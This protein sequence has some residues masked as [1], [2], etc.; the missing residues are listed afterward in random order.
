M[1]ETKIAVIGGTGLYEMEGVTPVDTFDIDTPFGTPSDSITVVD[2]DGKNVAFLPR[3]GRGHRYLPTEIPVKAN[4]WALKKLGVE[5][6]VAFSAVG[7]LRDQIRPR[8]IVVPDQII[9]RT[10]SRENSFFGEGIAG[11]VPFA[12][13]FCPAL[14]RV[15]AEIVASLPYPSH[16]EGTYVCMEGPLFSTRAESNL[17][18]SWGGS[19][20]GMT[21]IPEAKLAREAEICYS[22]IT[23]VTDYDC[24]K[25]EEEDVTLDMVIENMRANTEAAKSILRKIVKRLPEDRTCGCAEA[26]RYAIM[27][28]RKLI[29]NPVK[30]KL[31]LFYGKYF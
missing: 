26:A 13:P 24:W 7:S 30:D 18:R 14:R 11:H 9:D 28:D 6:I 25:Q 22:L 10:R 3:H 4:I 21:A 12:D 23:L 17:Y 16:D 19:I 15:V 8:D 27:T 20:I 29:P 31:D 5:R 2:L 1:T